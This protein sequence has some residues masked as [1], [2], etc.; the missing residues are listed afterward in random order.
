VLSNEKIPRKK[1]TNRAGA[2]VKQVVEDDLGRKMKMV[3][4]LQSFEKVRS[5]VLE[6]RGCGTSRIRLVNQTQGSKMG[7]LQITKQ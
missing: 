4:G 1:V 3:G 7:A 5:D 2:E 6:T